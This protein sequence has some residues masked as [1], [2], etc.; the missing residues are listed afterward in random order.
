MKDKIICRCCGLL[1][2]FAEMGICR[3]CYI[4]YQKEMHGVQEDGSIIENPM[5]SHI[6]NTKMIEWNKLKRI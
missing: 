1:P 6:W 3:R 5:D 2:S 4:I